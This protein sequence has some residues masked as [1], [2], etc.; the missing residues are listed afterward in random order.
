MAERENEAGSAAD[1]GKL[2]E[3]G[4]AVA[5]R[6]LLSLMQDTQQKSELRVKVA[7]SV[8]DRVLGKTLEGTGGEGASG[9]IRF[10]GE[11]DAWSR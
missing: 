5:A 6:V 2:L 8:L 7:E 4:A 9:V 11:L 1:A 3:A 10:E